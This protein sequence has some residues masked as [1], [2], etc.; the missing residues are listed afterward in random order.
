MINNNTK[1]LTVNQLFEDKTNIVQNKIALTFNG[2]SLSYRRLNEMSNQLANYLLSNFNIN[3]NDIIGILSNPSE[4]II[5]SILGILKAGSAY[6]PL[7]SLFPD[8]RIEY[9]IND[10]D[11]KVLF[12]ERKLVQKIT[13]L[14]CK[15]IF[16]D[17]I[18]K[19]IKDFSLE[20]TKPST[21]SEDIAYIMYT[22]GT[23]GKPNGVE[24]P[25]RGIT[26]LV[27]EATYLPFEEDLTFLQ[28]STIS[29]DAATFEIWGALL[30]GHKLTIYPDRVVEFANLK[31]TIDQQ[32]I[33]CLFLTTSL[34]NVL[35][36]ENPFVL[37]SIKYILTGGEAVSVKHIRKAQEVLPNTQL[38]HV[39]GPTECTTFATSH[40]IAKVSSNCN[41]IPIGKAIDETVIYLFDDNLLPTADGE[42]GELYIGGKGLAL[43][44]HNNPKLTKER[45]I[46]HP[47]PQ[48][49]QERLYK[50]GDLC[51]IDAE[52]NLVFIGRKDNQIKIRG[53]RVEIGEI[54]N[55]FKRHVSVNQ[56]FVL[57]KQGDISIELTAYIVNQDTIQDTTNIKICTSIDL[58]SLKSDLKKWLPEYMIPTKIIEINRFPLTLNGKID[59][60]KL[61]SLNDENSESKHTISLSQT[62]HKLIA[63][64]NE[65][66]SSNQIC[67]EDSFFE[68]GGDSLKAT[69]MIYRINQL[70][71]VYITLGMFYKDPTIKNLSK[72]IEPGFHKT[73]G[74]L[75]D[76]FV[77]RDKPISLSP[78]QER[79]WVFNEFNKN[80]PVYNIPFRFDMWGI[81]N[82]SKFETALNVMLKRQESLRT[83]F[84]VSNG[85][86]AQI[87]NAFMPIPLAIKDVSHLSSDEINLVLR[88]QGRIPFELNE[89]NLIRW[90]IYKVTEE[91]HILFVN[92]HHI[93]FDGWSVAVFKKEIKDIYNAL[94]NNMEYDSTPP[95]IQYSEYACWQKELVNSDFYEKHFEYWKNK[96]GKNPPFT[97]L[98]PDFARPT[99]QTFNGQTKEIWLSREQLLEIK[100]FS[101]KKRVTMYLFLVSCF[102]TVL[103][104]YTNQSRIT[105][106]SPN[107]NRTTHE[108]QNLIGFFVNNMLLSSDF[109]DEITFDELLNQMRTNF[110][111]AFEFQ[112]VPF[113]KLV[114]HL[115]DHRD[116][117]R[118]PLFQI[119]FILQNVDSTQM[120]LEGIKTIQHTI[121]NHTSKYDFTLIAEEYDDKLSLQME[122]NSDIYETTTIY[123][124]LNNFKTLI[125]DAIANPEKQVSDLNLIHSD[126]K[127]ILFS[128]EFTSFSQTKTIHQLF[129]E[130]VA[131][132]PNSTAVI[133]KNKN[134]TYSEINQRANQLA[135]FLTINNYGKSDELIGVMMSR[136]E[137][138]LVSLIGIM[139]AGS[140]YIP[141]DYNYPTDRIC[142]M[143]EN[144]QTKVVICDNSTELALQ[145]L[146]IKF[147]LINIEKD[148]PVNSV[149]TNPINNTKSSDLAYCIYTSGS[150]GNPKAVMLEHRSVVNLIEGVFSQTSI[151]QANNILCLTTFCFDI[152]VV[153][154]WIPLTKGIP[155]IMASED[156]NLEPNNIVALIKKHSIEFIQ[157]TPSRMEWLLLSKNAESAIK[158]IQTLF[159]GG[160]QLTPKLIEKIK[161]ISDA[162]IFN[163]Y[164]PTE[165]TVWSTF[166]QIENTEITIGKP[167]QNN[168]V[169]ILDKKRNVCPI[170]V[171][172]EIAIGG[173][174]LARGYLNNEEITREKFIENP[175]LKNE[176][177]YLTGDLGRRLNNG[178]FECLGRVDFQVKVR[179]HRIELGEIENTI[180]QNDQ[181]KE[182]IVTTLEINSQSE[183]IA[184]LIV[185]SEFEDETT[186]FKRLRDQLRRKLPS[187][188]IPSH[189][190]VMDCFPLNN[191]GKIDRKN[192]PNSL[193]FENTNTA[194][195][196]DETLSQTEE[197][198]VKLWQS[199]LGINQISIHDN[200]FELGGYSLLAVNLIHEI[201][202]KF[203]TD[204]TPRDI[205]RSPN[206][207]LLAKDI[208]TKTLPQELPEGIVKIRGGNSEN[209]FMAPGNGG[210]AFTF[211][212]FA[213]IFKG[214]HTIY[215]FEYPKTKENN[216]PVLSIQELASFFVE[217]ILKI[218]STGI[219]NLAGYSLGG[220][221]AFE[222][223][224]QLQDKGCSIG[225]IAMIDAL[226]IKNYPT[227]SL[228]LTNLLIEF[229]VF[230]NQN[231]TTK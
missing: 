98:R 95:Q 126:E 79:M 185:A 30:N 33:N 115:V 217:R 21:T 149:S 222:I 66:L 50:T 4:K 199:I 62:E 77:E 226:G 69:L 212:N 60:D 127:A 105:I 24:I 100:S 85:S 123:Q 121:D 152:F 198:L 214:P 108:I 175:F 162:K 52:G 230:F 78:G 12:V 155:L 187:Y 2:I 70:F 150:T 56:C 225:L 227:K 154:S 26:R 179:G 87:I 166:K 192:L 109:S 196:F 131:I 41:A 165:T 205:F 46:Q 83:S 43:G 55:A 36:D 63:I 37:Q 68:I 82:V 107:A 141:L 97:E 67:V 189:F 158:R 204:L 7:S 1:E 91:Y 132:K 31:Q 210:N 216:V 223:G 93:I 183:L 228:L 191:N 147:E 25:H 129:E 86:P 15:M 92:T 32:Y 138:L 17:E 61:S 211:Q 208:E 116:A 194:N 53:F 48:N 28:L 176:R 13:N 213:K 181:I 128:N 6:L 219:Y 164:G 215:A 173:D 151:N 160:E 110:H 200:F 184:Y 178:D 5:L 58:K 73:N 18:E 40:Q 220:R 22:S 9:M 65:L 221:L 209:I 106:G 112:S 111:E 117:S 145:N 81:L 104:R 193:T 195:P 168:Q 174:S 206:I 119:L 101:R 146:S 45:F 171:V 14:N 218:Q 114:E 71:D 76:Y 157:A 170:G 172:G 180:L 153:E 118:S 186:E 224:L 72:I 80:Q 143:I 120:D 47:L 229:D 75:A 35:I 159:I 140:A 207:D 148:I 23:T 203:D 231:F 130:Q 88:E 142:F 10:C 64:W 74:K 177:I 44:Y 49:K 167:I 42:I 103:Y 122:Y 29:F 96:I 89:Q 156:D 137:H 20:N 182:C 190:K 90:I 94:S 102:K 134:F 136:S 8:E 54:E 19:L 51:K 39:Y 125:C 57:S 34:F 202:L 11:V 144:S 169:Y 135:H 27:F 197:V 59:R 163:M 201:N 188:M 99:V 113:E 3:S 139:K 133:F 124:F 84:T 38:I 161:S 16:I